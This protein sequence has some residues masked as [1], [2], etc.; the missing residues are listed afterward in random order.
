MI[1]SRGESLFFPKTKTK[2]TTAIYYQLAYENG[3]EISD[4]LSVDMAKNSTIGDFE[5]LSH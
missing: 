5:L 2:M 3:G 4:V 1:K